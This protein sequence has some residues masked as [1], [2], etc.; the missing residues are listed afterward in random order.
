MR[1]SI[2]LTPVAVNVELHLW[3]TKMKWIYLVG[4]R[5]EEKGT[6]ESF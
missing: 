1:I 2:T 5:T 4:L 3:N 6:C